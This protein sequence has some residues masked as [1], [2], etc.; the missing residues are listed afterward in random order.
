MSWCL[1]TAAVVHEGVASLLD[2]GHLEGLDRLA[3][4]AGHP[5]VGRLLSDAFVEANFDFYGR[6]LTGFFRT[7]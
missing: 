3:A 6:T 7:S 5:L 4:L 2:A 1:L